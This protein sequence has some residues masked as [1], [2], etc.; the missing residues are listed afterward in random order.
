MQEQKRRAGAGGRSPKQMRSWDVA[1]TSSAILP[2]QF[3]LSGVEPGS[4]CGSG[5]L[6]LLLLLQHTG[7][8]DRQE[9]AKVVALFDA[10]WAINGACCI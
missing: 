7:T 6:F 9:A 5:S 1:S 2:A 8:V 3:R 10:V 4:G